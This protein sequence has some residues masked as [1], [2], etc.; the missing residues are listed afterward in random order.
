MALKTTNKLFRNDGRDIKY[1]NK[2]FQQFRTNLIEFSKTYFPKAFSD[3]NEASPAMLFIEMAS[4]VGD[5]LSY[6]IDDTLKES[7]IVHAEDLRNVLS[8][9]QY[10]GYRPKVTSPS[11]V[12]LSVY[13]LVPSIGVGEANIPDERFYLRI[14]EGMTVNSNTGIQFITTDVVDFNGDNNREITVYSRDTNTG[15]PVFYL[16]KK[17]VNA[18]SATIK[19]ETFDF[20]SFTPFPTITLSD[21]N[22][23][24]IQN[25]I[26]DNGSRYYEVPYLAQETVYIEEKN[27]DINNP[28]FSQFRTESPSRLRLLKTPRRFI[29]RVN[30][31]S[32]TTITFGS[33]GGQSNEELL[34]PNLKNVG[35]GL[36]NSINNLVNSID[37]TNFLRT[38]SYGTAPKN[39]TITVQYLVG[40]GV[41]SNVASNT[42]TNITEIAFDNDIS[43]FSVED[44]AIYNRIISSVAVDN[45]LPASGG[46]GGETIEEIRQNSLAN[47][48]SQNRAVTDRDY[49]VRALSMPPKFGSVSKSFAISDGSIDVNSV[50]SI[51]NSPNLLDSFTD[52]VMDFKN[53]DDDVTRESI[54]GAVNDFIK[55]TTSYNSN[56][57]AV[58]LYVLGYDS[59]KR[60]TNLSRIV[61]EN[62]KTYLNEHRILTD[63]VNILDGFIV[64]LSLEFDIKV[65]NNYNKSEVILNCIDELRDYFDIDKWT[66]NQSINISDIELLLSNVEGVKSVQRLEFFNKFGGEYS[67]SRYDIN[68]AIVGKILYPSV[69]PCVFEIKFPNK[70]IRGRVV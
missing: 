56:P 18:I 69:D 58:N 52:L 30:E 54:S 67:P 70:D 9:S 2:D 14:R 38:N 55:N 34:I 13:Q 45:E 11:V 10:L 53:S 50:K 16:V 62:L 23:I 22:V 46:R 42:I 28:Q 6:Y 31:D 65:Y 12:T 21:T 33:G 36:P 24:E 27:D 29:S 47:F 68:S 63:S 40:G 1:L 59:N 32:T 26:D 43:A 60:L 15:D 66:F 48:S 61:K 25:I 49:M 57:F 64:N 41:E 35:L 39:T 4:Y 37:P 51:L 44:R 17:E 7:L 5:V 3:F 20:G 8:L 19:S